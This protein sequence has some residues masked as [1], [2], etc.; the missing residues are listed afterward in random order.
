M[1]HSLNILLCVGIS[2][3]FLWL[4]L[5]QVELDALVAQIRA[6]N[7]IWIAVTVLVLLLAHGVRALRWGILLGFPA[8]QHTRPLFSSMMIGY[9]GNNVLPARMGEVLRIYALHRSL[10]TSRS[11]AGAT[12]L[13][14][15]VLDLVV[16]IG[17]VGVLS[18]FVE[19]PDA[20][21]KFGW[22][23]LAFFL[24]GIAVLIGL[25][26]GGQHVA[27]IL[28]FWTR[29][30]SHST[31]AR[32]ELLMQRFLSGMDALK[33]ISRMLRIAGLTVVV[34]GAEAIAVAFIF[35]SLNL[36]SPWQAAPF[37]L[38]VLSLSFVIPA[39]PGGIGTYEY[40]AG[41]ALGAFSIGDSQAAAVA[42][43]LHAVTF[44]VATGLG[45]I[46]LWSE[47]L[48]LKVLAGGEAPTG[49]ISCD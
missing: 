36:R 34:W 13:V 4:A 17:V 16:L 38:V 20:I 12:I 49:A 24:T 21:A 14:E 5:R 32:I 46:C 19:L 37:L 23:L 45:L 43:V 1:R 27:R 39:A 33:S 44:L 29:R 42:L 7:A 30:V 31:G 26:V 6:V 15:R 9:L 18:Y 3:L 28:I 2:A 35:W 11:M 10:N 40:F 47:S 22:V 8:F 25:V 48:S 41:V